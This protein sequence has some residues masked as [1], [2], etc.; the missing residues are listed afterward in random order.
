MGF[1]RISLARQ[2]LGLA[3]NFSPLAGEVA[4]SSRR[5]K[6]LSMTERSRKPTSR[7]EQLMMASLKPPGG[8]AYWLS[9]RWRSKVICTLLTPGVAR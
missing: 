9:G 7:A 8:I 4:R 5:P 6:S 1:E 2:Q 3:L